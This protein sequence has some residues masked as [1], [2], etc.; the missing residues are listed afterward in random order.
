MIKKSTIFDFIYLQL[1]GV[2]I[3]YAVLFW[4]TKDK[5]TEKNIEKIFGEIANLREK[6]QI[7]NCT[8]IVT[9]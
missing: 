9:A 7:S 4:D 5:Q 2:M 3:T 1:I 8:C 6:S